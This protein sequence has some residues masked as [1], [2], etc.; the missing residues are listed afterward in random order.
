MSAEQPI[1]SRLADLDEQ[2]AASAIRVRNVQTEQQTAIAER[3][4]LRHELTEAFADND[5]ATAKRLQRDLDKA[6]KTAAEPWAQKVDGAQLAAERLRGEREHY[7]NANWQALGK[8]RRPEAQRRADAVNDAVQA[9]HL[10]S[11]AWHAYANESIALLRPVHGV[12]SRAI[13]DLGSSGIG[14][15][16][17]QAQRLEDDAPLPTW[18]TQP[19]TTITIPDTDSPDDDVREAA[20]AKVLSADALKGVLARRTPTAEQARP[21]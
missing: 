5:D 6:E 1:T 18:G 21:E 7:L 10:A 15:L 19:S 11:Q 3:D 17:R 20:R 13:P 16:V 9:L 8:E 12:D 14:D 4:R 2:I